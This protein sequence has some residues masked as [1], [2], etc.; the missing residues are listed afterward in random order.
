MTD[1]VDR[2]AAFWAAPNPDG[3]ET[4]ADEGIVLRY[5][6]V[7]EPMTGVDA[8]KERVASIVERFPDVRLDVTYHATVDDLCFISWRASATSQGRAISWEGTD[9]MLLRNGRVI[10]SM[11][12]FDTSGFRPAA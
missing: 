2:W 12:A 4:I 8:W 6:G 1:F 3:V 7:P 10:D 11:V 5:P 9:R